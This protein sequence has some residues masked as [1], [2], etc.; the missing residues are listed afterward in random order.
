MRTTIKPGEELDFATPAEVRDILDE[1]LA[2]WARGPQTIRAVNALGL[3]G[4][5]NGQVDVYACPAGHRFTLHRLLIDLDEGDTGYNPGNPY[6]SSDGYAD[7]LRAGVR[8]AF[9]VF[10][11]GL[12]CL[13]TDGS[14]QALEYSN[15]EVVQVKIVGGPADGTIVVRLQGTIQPVTVN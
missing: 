5:G 4:N 9:A 2:P 10:S 8:E 12:P 15:G 3:D 11:G 7:I 1:S 14:R 6:T 13:F